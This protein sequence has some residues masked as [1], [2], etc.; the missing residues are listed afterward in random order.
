M[1][2]RVTRHAGTFADMRPGFRFAVLPVAAVLLIA[3][4][5][6]H[7]GVTQSAAGPP[8]ASAPASGGAPGAASAAP[9]APLRSGERFLTLTMPHAYTPVPPSGATDEYRCFLLDPGFTQRTFITGD[10]F[11]PQNAAIVHHA[12]FFRVAPADVAQA[13]AVDA[14]DP[15]DGWTCFGG[16]G[17][18]GSKG[19]G[20]L[21]QGAS[22]IAA[23]APGAKESV[24]ASN[25]GYEMQPGSQII[26]QIHYNLLATG[27]KATGS[28]QSGIRLRL[29]SGTANLSPLQTTL[30]PAPVELPCPAG[31]TG[32]LCKRDMA[33]LD[34][35]HRFGESAA[36]TVAGLN[37]LCDGGKPPVPGPTQSCELKVRTAGTVYAVAG[38]MH[39]LGR[40]I[41]VELNPG[42]PQAKVLLDNTNYNFDDQS[43]KPLATPVVVKPGDMYKVTCT[44][45]AQLRTLLPQLR[46]LPPRY[47]VWGEGT[48]DEMCLGIVVWSPM[49]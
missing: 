28:D 11:L 19:T 36:G 7:T 33:I 38:H 3:G 27:G 23:W 40:S 13:R 45:D 25:L 31:V 6:A 22:W 39:L 5:A 32:P 9:A 14:A 30:L 44:H 21:R 37:L 16:T 41:K 35:W 18:A 47:V 17:V 15:G 48:S 29:A 24:L 46:P 12:I 10:Q 20:Q 8:A 42:T 43:A 34:L 2:Y 49:P 26:M 4:C 1:L